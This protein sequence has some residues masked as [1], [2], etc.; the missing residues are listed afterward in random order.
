MVL[1]LKEW[2]NKEECVKNWKV[3]RK[4]MKKRL[5]KN[6]EVKRITNVKWVKSTLIISA[7]TWRMEIGKWDICRAMRAGRK[8]SHNKGTK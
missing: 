5:K 1:T 8:K 3:L 6:R 2:L 4:K 7:N